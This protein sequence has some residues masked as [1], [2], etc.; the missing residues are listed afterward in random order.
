M[1]LVADRV[2][3]TVIDLFDRLEE[4]GVR[5]ALMRNHE[6]FPRFDHD[7]DL[8]METSA[9][10]D[11]RRLA[12]SVAERHGW[13]ALTEC[14]HWSQSRYRHHNIETLLF[15]H[16]EDNACL[17]VDVFHGFLVWGLPFLDEEELL[18]RRERDAE[19]RFTRLDPAL[20]NLLRML[21][22]HRLATSG[23]GSP[24]VERYRN[25]VVKF[26]AEQ[27]VPLHDPAFRRLAPFVRRAAASLRSGKMWGYR[28]Q[29]D[30]ARL[31]FVARYSS[32][33]PGVAIRLVMVRAV[34]R[35]RLSYTRQC[36][37]V[38]LARVEDDSRR[39]LL[40]R[41]LDAL[42]TSNTIRGWTASGATRR[43]VRWQERKVMEQ[44]GIAVKWADTGDDVAI[45]L[46]GCASDEDARRTI[47]RLL[48]RRHGSLWRRNTS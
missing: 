31:A 8:V 17:Q 46:E 4:S 18:A 6:S 15:Y 7:V 22:I 28:L 2:E 12:A 32:M 45:D 23:P 14:D 37:F 35:A 47:V 40:A 27:G 19:H 11:L 39:A 33:H 3:S 44:G 36:G 21:Q 25:R 26:F 20:E 38:L 43:S 34:D 48:V 29:M 13:D 9:L 16:L 1:I 5:Y 42:V 10:P 24:K 30:L 41:A